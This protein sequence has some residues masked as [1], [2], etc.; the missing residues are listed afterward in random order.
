MGQGWERLV[1][2]EVHGGERRQPGAPLGDAV[3][4]ARTT[5]SGL[6]AWVWL[7][8]QSPVVSAYRCPNSPSKRAGRALKKE[9]VLLPSAQTIVACEAHG[10][11]AETPV[12][13]QRAELVDLSLYLKHSMLHMARTPL[14]PV[15][16]R[17]AEVAVCIILGRG[18]DLEER[19]RRKQEEEQACHRAQRPLADRRNFGFWGHVPRR[20]ALPP[21]PPH[22]PHEVLAN[23]SGRQ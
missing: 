3:P 7:C 4:R 18:A 14:L 15:R 17:K 6:P 5:I 13:H 9:D 21:P 12:G 22:P 19:I 1:V 8:A 16:P 20:P 11:W 2:W 10:S 23:R